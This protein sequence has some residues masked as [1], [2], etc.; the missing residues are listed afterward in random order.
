MALECIKPLISISKTK[1]LLGCIETSIDIN[2]AEP[3]AGIILAV[4]SRRLRVYVNCRMSC[5]VCTLIARVIV[6]DGKFI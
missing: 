3:G 2:E 5:R 4:K 1:D 6:A